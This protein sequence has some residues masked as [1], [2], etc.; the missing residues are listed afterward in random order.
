MDLQGAAQA[1]ETQPEIMV[2]NL[3]TFERGFDEF[4]IATECKDEVDFRADLVDIQLV[5][6]TLIFAWPRSFALRQY[7]RAFAT[8]RMRN[9]NPRHTLYG[10]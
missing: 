5:I 3:A 7:Y 2:G 8:P 4:E 6:R 10:R 1:S 9:R